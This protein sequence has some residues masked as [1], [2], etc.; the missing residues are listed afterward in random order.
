MK[1]VYSGAEGRAGVLGFD[2][3]A[4]DNRSVLYK[5]MNTHLNNTYS[6]W[7]K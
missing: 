5:V 7:T 3:A 1:T 2:S 6:C 4:K